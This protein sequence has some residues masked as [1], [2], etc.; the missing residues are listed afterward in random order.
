MR[1]VVAPRWMQRS[2]NELG[3]EPRELITRDGV[4]LFYEVVGH[5]D[6]TMI[7][8]NGLGGRLYSWEPLIRAF[9]SE[10]RLLAW[11]YRGLFESDAPSH[12]RRLAIPEHAEDIREIM[13]HEGIK[14]ATMVGWSMG[15][16][17][18][19]ETASLFPDQI[20][21]LVLL[22]GSY[23]K[24]L[25]TAFQPLFRVPWFN[26]TLHEFI[27][28]MYVRPGPVHWVS[29]HFDTIE[30][31]LRRV[32]WAYG[33]LLYKNPKL[34]DLLVQY[35]SDLLSTDFGNYLRLFQ[36]LDSHSVYHLLRDIKQPS[37]VV[38]GRLDLLTPAY[39]SKEMV[40]KLPHSKHI[41]LPYGSHFVLIEYPEEVVKLMRDFFAGRFKL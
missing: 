29:E 34:K 14:K 13:E 36:E 31:L 19:L 40:R 2:R 1:E 20:D 6:K 10:Y 23:G 28:F 26:K 3:I 15:V 11:D 30:P 8:A 16:Q 22:N 21:R 38:S 5:G 41:C 18:S 32:G 39:L 35:M 4:R 24:V 37:L 25:D 9:S 27:D 12:I 7:L 17:V 33:N